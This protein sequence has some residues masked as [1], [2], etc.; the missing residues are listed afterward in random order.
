GPGCNLP[1]RAS[2]GWL[3]EGGIRVPLIVRMPDRRNAGLEP[4][5]PVVSTDIYPTLLSLAGL[6]LRPEQHRDGQSFVGLMNGTG[7]D[8]APR[9]LYWHYPHYHGSMWTP[10]AA[11][12]KGDWKLIQFYHFD[13]LELYNL[14]EDLGESTDLSAAHPEV[15]QTLLAELLKWQEKLGASIPVVREVK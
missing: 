13:K 8:S 1:L 12:R 3:Y 2:K 15:T 7:R 14:Q 5:T 9:K 10:G 6:P 4:N 11:I